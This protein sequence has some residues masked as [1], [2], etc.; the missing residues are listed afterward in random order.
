MWRWNPCLLL[1]VSIPCQS[2]R[3]T[4]QLVV[5]PC[6]NDS[7]DGGRGFR[8]GYGIILGQYSSSLNNLRTIWP[9]I[10]KDTQP[11][12][13]EP[14]SSLFVVVAVIVVASSPS[15]PGHIKSEQPI[16]PKTWNILITHATTSKCT[17]T[18]QYLDYTCLPCGSNPRLFS[19]HIHPSDHKCGCQFRPPWSSTRLQS[20]D[21]LQMQPL[22]HNRCKLCWRLKNCS[23][24]MGTRRPHRLLSHSL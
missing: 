12:L 14:P 18:L 16:K 6:D 2:I 4:Q 21:N 15:S 9:C 3:A 19:T 22:V 7:P 11:H 24:W 23:R 1:V 5:L 20:G 10:S 17:K 8:L 13:E